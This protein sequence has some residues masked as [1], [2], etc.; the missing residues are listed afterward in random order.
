MDPSNPAA[1]EII[2]LGEEIYTRQYKEEY[3]LEHAGKYVAVDVDSEAAYTADSPEAALRD[4]RA[5]TPEGR[6]HVM[7]IQATIR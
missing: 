4:A 3:E 7:L 1:Q 6:F 2:D 5:S